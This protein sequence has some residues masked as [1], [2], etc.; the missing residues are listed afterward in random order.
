[1]RA[2]L[3]LTP[4][5][6]TPAEVLERVLYA[7]V[8]EGARCVEEGVAASPDDV[9][10]VMAL[11]FGFPAALGGPMRW[12]R[13]AVGYAEVVRALD[14]YARAVHPRFTPAGWLR[15]RSR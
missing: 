4:R 9:D 15:A 5:A 8:N 12:A 3:G 7:T 14:R 6:V 2:E 13:E 1:V 11:G 10:T